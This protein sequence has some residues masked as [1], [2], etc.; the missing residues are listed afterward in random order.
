MLCTTRGSSWIG[1][2]MVWSRWTARAGSLHAG[3]PLATGHA[4]VCQS[5]L[6]QKRQ[7]HK[8]WPHTPHDS[9][10]WAG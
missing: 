2:R 5:A 8:A 1:L 3:S 6:L 7:V 9:A 10:A 4:A